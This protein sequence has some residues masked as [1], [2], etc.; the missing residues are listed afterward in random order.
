M[1]DFVVV[2]VVVVEQPCP[3]SGGPG[4]SP[5]ALPPSPPVLVEPPTGKSTRK[6]GAES[7]RK[8]VLKRVSEAYWSQRKRERE[9]ADEAQSSGRFDNGRLWVARSKVVGIVRVS[10][11][12]HL[13][14][15]LL[16]RARTTPHSC[17]WDRSAAEP[18][19]QTFATSILITLGLRA[20]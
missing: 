18:P 4:G 20:G 9:R 7:N 2:V 1:C 15:G 6:K 3:G 17:H 19:H 8:S 11:G 12:T 14:A 10:Q 16:H 5:V 13:C